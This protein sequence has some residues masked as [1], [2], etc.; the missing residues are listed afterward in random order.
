MNKYSLEIVPHPKAPLFKTPQDVKSVLRHI[1]SEILSDSFDPEDIH[2]DA[3]EFMRQLGFV[4]LWF[5]LKFIAGYSGPYDELNTSLNVDM[6]NFRQ[7]L[8]QPG[9]KGAAFLARFHRKSTV[10]T[11]GA[12][13][14]ELLRN[15]DLRIGLCR[16][17]GAFAE[18]FMHNTK[19]TFEE[20]LLVRALYP[21]YVPR[22]N[23]PRWNARE[24]VMPNRTHKA[25]EASITPFGATA[26]SAGMHFDMIVYDDI[27][28]DVQLNAEHMSSMDM[29]KVKNW[30]QSSQRTLLDNW[31]TGRIITVGTRY[32]VDDPYEDIMKNTREAYGFWDEIPYEPRPDGVWHT[33]YRMIKERGEIIFPERITEEGLADM[34]RE[35]PWGAYTQMFN[36]PQAAGLTEFYNYKTKDITM[37]Y[38]PER[39]DFLVTKYGEHSGEKYVYLS[40]CHVVGS[41]DP[42]STDKGVSAKTSRTAISVWALDPD[43]CFLNIAGMA[44]Y[45]SIDEWMERIFTL[46][47]LF[48][49]F[50]SQF[51]IEANAMQKIIKPFLDREARQRAIYAPF[52]ARPETRDKTVRIRNALGGPLAK[53]EIYL[54]PE[55]RAIFTEEK[56][57]FP[58]NV[59]RMDYLDSAEKCISALKKPLSREDREKVEYRKRKRDRARGSVITG[60]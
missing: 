16:S 30:F 11:H 20:N 25:S 32:S 10:F 36:L 29:L 49:G 39:E 55:V 18:E 13:T 52:K 17:K 43:D 6:C 33:Y 9:I 38:D 50:L 37:E 24:I 12:N 47:Q 15:P 41:I 19:D 46:V 58:G 60:Y 26:S 4:S 2:E 53:G 42:A 48:Q 31:H 21:E 1:V 56:D 34:I 22:A 28:S 23:Q 57:V 7:S 27:I 44:G 8:L 3:R 59:Y 35:D 45:W 5:F 40:E 51:I 54:V 14:W